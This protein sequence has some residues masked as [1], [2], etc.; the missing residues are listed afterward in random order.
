MPINNAS[1][2]LDFLP[3]SL[4]DAI[5]IS[6]IDHL[7]LCDIRTRGSALAFQRDAVLRALGGSPSALTQ[8]R[9]TAFRDQNPT[10]LK[11]LGNG[12]GKKEEKKEPR[13]EGEAGRGSTSRARQRCGSLPYLN[14][15]EHSSVLT[16]VVGLEIE[17]SDVHLEQWRMP[18]ADAKKSARQTGSDPPLR[19]QQ[20]RRM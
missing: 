6:R 9:P 5:H 11:M 4:Q 19:S 17:T 14:P 1:L 8:D 18:M 10:L 12:G 20:P 7:G 15:A 2:F 3:A 13:R 16:V